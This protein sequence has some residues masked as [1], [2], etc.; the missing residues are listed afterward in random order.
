VERVSRINISHNLRPNEMAL[1]DY[2]ENLAPK[3]HAR[4]I[5]C[6]GH[7]HN[8]ERFSQHGVIYLV[9]GGGG[10][11]PVPVERTPDDLYQATDFPNFHY[12]KFELDGKSLRATMIRLDQSSAPAH[13]WQQR[14]QF[15]ISRP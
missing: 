4:M 3:L 2:L 10:A 15:T 5:V 6:A 12:V 14:D 1:R 8:Y 9:S 7:I 11:S 13:Q